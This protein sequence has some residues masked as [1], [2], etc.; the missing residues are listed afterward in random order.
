MVHLKAPVRRAASTR[1]MVALEHGATHGLGRLDV[2]RTERRDRQRAVIEIA[3][4]STLEP[5]AWAS[6]WRS[7]TR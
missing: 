4:E 5:S 3:T 2:G 6:P 7:T 1:G